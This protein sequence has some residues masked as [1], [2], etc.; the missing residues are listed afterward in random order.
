M[1]SGAVYSASQFT[2]ETRHSIPWVLSTTPKVNSHFNRFSFMRNRA[3][4][5]SPKSLS[6]QTLQSPQISYT[7]GTHGIFSIFSFHFPPLIARW[8]CWVSSSVRCRRLVV[9]SSSVPSVPSVRWRRRCHRCRR[10]FGRGEE[11]RIRN[12][13]PVS[14]SR[15][16]SDLTAGPRRISEPLGGG[17]EK[18]FSS[19]YLTLGIRAITVFRRLCLLERKLV[20]T[21][22]VL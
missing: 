5:R 21:D 1:E 17:M 6:P 22:W 13:T 4:K 18:P 9:G 16:Q 10:R 3:K 19:T 15:E 8:A 20:E 12:R 11:L 7:P 2:L 14:S